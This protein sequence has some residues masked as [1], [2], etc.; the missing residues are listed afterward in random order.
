MEM[1]LNPRVAILDYGAGNLTSVRLALRRIGADA[2]VTRDPA[3]VAAA[4]R[5]VFPGVGSAASGMAGLRGCGLD[6][7]LTEAIRGGKPVLAIC[8]GMQMLLDWSAEDG[9]AD[10]LGVIPGRVEKFEFPAGGVKVPHMGWNTVDFRSAHPLF[11]GIPSGTAF[12][13]VH[14]YFARPRDPENTL[15][16]TEYGGTEFAC[17]IGCGNVFATQFHPERSGEAGLRMLKNFA[18]WDGAPCC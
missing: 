8:L 18:G 15:G 1:S 2:Q 3:A 13:F 7:A 17:V 10:G 9:G 5:I 6:A 14:S 16:T 4:D 12:Y 11:A